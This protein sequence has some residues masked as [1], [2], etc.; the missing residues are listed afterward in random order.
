MRIRPLVAI[1]VCVAATTAAQAPPQAPPAQSAGFQLNLTGATL[2]EV[3]DILARQL[4]MNYILDPSVR[5]SVT[6]NTYGELQ[7]P[8]VMPLLETILRMNGFAAVQVGNLYRIVPSKDA[9][10]LPIPPQMDP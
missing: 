4:K 3:I 6:I 2:Q 7:V 5:G 1:L 8:D 10:R 9:V